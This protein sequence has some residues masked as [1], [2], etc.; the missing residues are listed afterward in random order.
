MRFLSLHRSRRHATLTRLAGAVS[1]S[2]LKLDYMALDQVV[3]SPIVTKEE[4]ERHGKETE[5]LGQGGVMV[6]ADSGGESGSNG[7]VER[8]NGIL[9]GVGRT[10][11][12]PGDASKFKTDRQRAWIVGGL[13][14]TKKADLFIQAYVG[15]ARYNATEAA[16]IAGYRA[17][18]TSGPTLRK[19]YQPEIDKLMEAAK[20]K[21]KVSPDEA[22]EILAQVAR[23]RG[24]RDRV[25]AVELILKVHGM[26]NDKM[27]LTLDRTQLQ[28]DLD[29][30]LQQLK[31]HKQPRLMS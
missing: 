13:R 14:R 26:F 28:R 2:M 29:T 21:L 6:G 20:D 12:G 23:E 15:E 22:M 8:L 24:N 7:R 18:R 3:D 4:T 5:G 19:K 9:E 1:P 30:V 31:E 10:K 27:T 11:Y 16:R 25:R 17:P